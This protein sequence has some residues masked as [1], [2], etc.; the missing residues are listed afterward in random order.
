M[1]NQ[2][3]HRPLGPPGGV[4]R[5]VSTPPAPAAAASD[6]DGW[7]GPVAGLARLVDG[8]RRDLNPLIALPERVDELASLVAGLA[9]ALAAS[10]ARR[11]A[12][13]APSW[14]LAPTDTQNAAEL[15]DAL[16]GWL[17]AVFLRYPD[18]AAALPDCWCWHPDIVE[19]LV[20]LM[21]AWSAA[22]Q[23]PAAS[24]GLAGDWH[25]RQ[26]PGVVRRIRGAAGSCSRENHQTRPGRPPLAT[27]APTVPAAAEL[28]VIAGWWAVDR[29]Y[30]AP[31]PA[32][33]GASGPTAQEGARP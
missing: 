32:S 10:T 9:D 5:T 3:R 20:W 15:L 33:A 29:D 8:L 26:R 25:D 27:G 21:H 28:T 11:H 6:E 23:G 18:G 14:L 22:Y 7:A 24:V 19:E 1:S 12:A 31:E 30:P 16:A 17:G 4:D 13:P 2:N